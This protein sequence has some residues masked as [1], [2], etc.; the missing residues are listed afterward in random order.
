MLLNCVLQ[1]LA[2]GDSAE[3]RYTGWLEAGGAEGTVF[4]GNMKKD[5]AFRFRIGKGKVIKGA[6][7]PLGMRPPALS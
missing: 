5:K 6:F 3:V 1:A 7:S 2:A 4:D